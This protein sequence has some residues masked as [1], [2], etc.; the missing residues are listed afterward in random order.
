MPI[1]WNKKTSSWELQIKSK[2]ELE[3][4]LQTGKKLIVAG[5]AQEHAAQ[6]FTRW[7]NMPEEKMFG[8][9]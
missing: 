9:Q 3:A 8:P 7:L 6:A 1:V 2:E 4:V 5:T